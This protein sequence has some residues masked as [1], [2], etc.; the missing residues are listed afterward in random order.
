MD[1]CESCKTKQMLLDSILNKLNF[2][3]VEGS[4]EECIGRIMDSMDQCD[5]C[6]K[7]SSEKNKVEIEKPNLENIQQQFSHYEKVKLLQECSRLGKE[8]E[9]LRNERDIIQ[10]KYDAL[11][12][13]PDAIHAK[14]I[15]L[16][17]GQHPEV[18]PDESENQKE[19][20]KLEVENEHLRQRINELECL[21]NNSNEPSH[22][23]K[24]NFSDD[25]SKRFG[26]RLSN[27]E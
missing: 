13:D 19:L 10:Q 25:F 17:K 7:I 2:Q 22:F 23:L 9:D 12:K 16:M 24:P 3:T 5:K 11:K 21:S 20:K 6:K 14:L 4:Q 26:S 15:N 8:V 18:K 27:N 1:Q